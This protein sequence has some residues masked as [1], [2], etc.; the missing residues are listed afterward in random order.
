MSRENTFTI[1]AN[2]LKL[3]HQFNI[4]W[5]D[6]EYGAPSVD[7]KRPYGNSS[8]EEDIAEIIGLEMLED[9]DG[10]KHFPKGGR[11]VCRKLHKEMQTVLQIICATMQISEGNYIQEESYD[12][13]SWRKQND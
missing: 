5:E 7:C 13:Q 12:Y 3:L 6:C 4:H 2:H 1:T 10:E 9:D 11:D 8:V